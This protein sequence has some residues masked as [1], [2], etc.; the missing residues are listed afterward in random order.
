VSASIAKLAI[1]VLG[2]KLPAHGEGTETSAI[3][4]GADPVDVPLGARVDTTF[5]S[6]L[7]PEGTME[8]VEDDFADEVI[9]P[10]FRD[11]VDSASEQDAAV[12][13]VIPIIGDNDPVAVRDIV[14][15]KLSEAQAAGLSAPMA[16]QLRHVL[17]TELMDV[18]RINLTAD[19]PAKVTPVSCEVDPGVRSVKH[20]ARTYTREKSRFMEVTMN[21]LEECG[22]VKKTPQATIASPAHV[23]KKHDVDPMAPIEQ[24]YRLTVDLRAVNKFTAPMQFPIPRLEV[25]AEMV[26]GAKMFGKLDL[27]NGFWQIPIDTKS[28]KY[29]AIRTDVGVWTPTRLIQGARNST[30]IFQSVMREVLGELV[31]TA[32]VVYVDD[33]LVVGRDERD[34]VNNMTRVLR[35]LYDAGFKV[36]AKKTVFFK[37][38]VSFCGR[39]FSAKGV[40]FDDDYVKSVVAM[41]K[42]QDA[43]Q[44]R[45]YLASVNWMRS[46]IPQFSELVAPLQELLAVALRTAD[47]SHTAGMKKVGLRDI[48]WS[49]VHDAA[50]DAINRALGKAVQLGYPRDDMVLCVF[51]DASDKHWAGVVTQV[52]PNELK[53]PVLDQA[54]TPLAFVSGTFAGA[55]QRWPTVEKEGFGVVQTILRCAFMLQRREGF[56]LYTDH[57]NLKF[58]FNPDPMVSDGKKQSVERVERWMVMLRAFTFHI[59][60]IPGEDNVFADLLSRWARDGDPAGGKVMSADSGASGT[61]TATPPSPGDVVHPVQAL[62]RRREPPPPPPPPSAGFGDPGTVVPLDVRDDLPTELELK[63]AQSEVLTPEEIVRRSLH[64]NDRGLYV[65]GDGRI[66]VPDIRLLRLRI[67]IVA[68]QGAAAHRAIKVTTAIIRRHFIWDNQEDDIKIFCRQCL[69][70]LKTRG[71]K[72]TNRA[73]GMPRY[74]T[75]PGQRIHFDFMKIREAT[76][77]TPNGYEYV[78]VLVDEFSRFVELVPAVS[79]TAEVTA[80]ALL[81]WFKRFGLVLEWESDQGTHFL[82]DLMRR[83]Q[84]L[85]RCTHHFTVAY[86][87]WSNGRVERVNRELRE[88]LSVMMQEAE[89]PAE[90]W[91]YVLP[92]VNAAINNNISD[93]LGGLCPR[94]VFLGRPRVDPLDIIYNPSTKQFVLAP[95]PPEGIREWATSLANDLRSHQE[96]V[97]EVKHRMHVAKEPSG[98]PLNIHVGDYVLVSRLGAQPKD[99][100]RAIWDGPFRVVD[101]SKPLRFMV[102]DINTRHRREVHAVHLRMYADRAATVTQQLKDI[103]AYSSAGYLVDHIAAHRVLNNQWEV[104]VVWQGE[105]D[106]GEESRQSWEPLATIAK[107]VPV[108]VRQYGRALE[109]GTQEAFQQAL[110]ACGRE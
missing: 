62:G 9:S 27:F 15:Q 67:C 6:A 104:L 102:E 64:R 14:L 19:P 105:V 39:V 1:K 5:P 41:A 55:Q 31:G 107:D 7:V 79:A 65:S 33:L 68:H 95:P 35:A 59:H 94:T 86:A 11:E 71:G 38:E 87:P 63:T 90:Q 28:Q 21:R 51:T 61:V 30:A 49:P 103:A 98:T 93:A 58:I 106:P 97:A 2:G 92:A 56:E 60:H 4:I 50:F 12:L 36:S 45:S 23:V 18:F 34:F 17:M 70:C 73:L 80:L 25:F 83:M 47:N 74:A 81:D 100:T 13:D 54:H 8:E 72:V 16:D 24:Q 66:Y 76:P 26:S 48:G 20:G 32:A 85:L 77:D 96:T 22:W 69:G 108:I 40:R 110:E 88:I 46:S 101:E 57:R 89:L 78:L 84:E 99:K 29:F 42:P 91:P 82:N 3:D 37:P 109:G 10:T 52:A 53:L 75:A 44:L 43:A